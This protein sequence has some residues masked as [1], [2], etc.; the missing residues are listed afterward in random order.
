[1]KIK[2]R[3]WQEQYKSM[4]YNGLVTFNLEGF[5]S[6]N[7]DHI[8]MLSTGIFDADGIEIFADDLLKDAFGKIFRVYFIEGGF[9]IK[10]SVWKEDVKDF[11][12][13]DNL[14]SVP[15]ADAQTK[16]YVSQSCIVIGNNYS[17]IHKN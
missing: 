13:T 12:A 9:V 5:S 11:V 6:F 17:G 3:A 1:M 10:D 7:N 4:T 8:L 15:L 16:S 14:I 2:F